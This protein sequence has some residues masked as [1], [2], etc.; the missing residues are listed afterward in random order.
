MTSVTPSLLNQLLYFP[1]SGN[2]G[3]PRPVQ[4]KVRQDLTNGLLAYGGLN[5]VGQQTAIRACLAFEGM[6]WSQAKLGDTL[7]DTA[8][9][10]GS[11]LRDAL[12]QW[13]ICEATG[14]FSPPLD[15]QTSWTELHSTNNP[16]V[17]KEL[18]GVITDLMQKIHQSGNAIQAR[19]ALTNIIVP[20]LQNTAPSD[21]F[22][23][24]FLEMAPPKYRHDELPAITE[25]DPTGEKDIARRE[26]VDRLNAY[27]KVYHEPQ[28][29]MTALDPTYQLAQMAIFWYLATAKIG[30]PD[31]PT[32][33]QNSFAVLGQIQA[34]LQQNGPFLR[35]ESVLANELDY[36]EKA[37]RAQLEK[38]TPK[39]AE[40]PK[41]KEGN[42][43]IL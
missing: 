31:V 14:A 26:V 22:H 2:N 20:S 16:S 29:K 35:G 30:L 28:K 19:T 13:A 3:H 40:R 32:V 12:K 41:E 10:K 15:I 39:K 6:A 27:L 1:L 5:E 34:F 38:H 25:G 24:E 37:M 9:T 21:T 17:S 43:A 7:Q 8:A 36:I 4:T 18:N 11:V 42:C 23:P 33:C